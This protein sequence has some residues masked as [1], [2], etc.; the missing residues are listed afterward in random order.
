MA[1]PGAGRVLLVLPA[2][3]PVTCARRLV[4][5]ARA[6]RRGV[7]PVVAAL[8]LTAGCGMAALGLA[9]LLGHE[10]LGGC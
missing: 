2:A 9:T 5:V 3:L 8:A 4:T 7:S 1:V 10:I 6:L